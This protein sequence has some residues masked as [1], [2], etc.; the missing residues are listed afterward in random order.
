MDSAP[1]HIGIDGRELLGQP[2][3]V[4]R[5]LRE[6]LRVWSAPDFPHRLTV[7]VPAPPPA[8]LTALGPRVTGQVESGRGSGTVWEQLHLARAI[9]RAHV[10]VFFAAGYTAPL[11][12]SCPSVVA[13]YDVSFWAHPEWFPPREGFRRRWVTRFA[14][15]RAARVITISAFSAS[16]LA[17]FLGVPSSRIDLAPP[18]A[19]ARLDRAGGPPREPLVLYVGSIFARRHIPDLLQAFAVVVRR[20]P[21]ARLVLVGDN[22]TR[23][24]LDLAARIDA[25]GLAS[26]VEWRRYAPDAD[27]EA[28]Y[29]RARVFAFLSDYEGFAMTPLEALAHGVPSVLL[30]TPVAREVYGEAAAL[31]PLDHAAIA[32]ALLDLL[33]NDARRAAHLA[34]GDARLAAYAWTDTAAVIRRAL[35]EAARTR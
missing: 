14:A 1:L 29:A 17:R 30:E 18:G 28:L 22:R 9:R 7:F 2:T 31:V 26:R 8:E 5:Y 19:P 33:T 34:A 32:D 11:R 35:E 27:L 21:E 23:P 10:D 15:R 25:L 12:L 24:A 4:G 20:V 6:V 16:E 3:G 13:V